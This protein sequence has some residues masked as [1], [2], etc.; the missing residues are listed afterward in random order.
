MNHCK[1]HALSVYYN[2][3]LTI[4]DYTVI[5]GTHQVNK[6]LNVYGNITSFKLP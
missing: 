6:L 4:I 2:M 1:L 3:A 5:R